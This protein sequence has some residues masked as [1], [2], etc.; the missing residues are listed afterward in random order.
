M[1]RIL[2][3]KTIN[4]LG[5]VLLCSLLPA[6]YL[7]GMGQDAKAADM[8][9]YEPIG[10]QRPIPI[11]ILWLTGITTI[12][13]GRT[14]L[15]RLNAGQHV[16][17]AREQAP[18]KRAVLLGAGPQAAHIIRG[19]SEDPQLRYDIIGI[20]DDR[21]E[22]H[23]TYVQNVRIIGP[24]NTLSR[25]L[26]EQAVDEVIVAVQDTCVEEI[27][28][29]VIECRRQKLPVKVAPRLSEI[30]G[31][32]TAFRLLDFSVEDFL[33]RRSQ[34]DAD[35]THTSRS[36]AGKRV[37]VTGAG[38]SIGSEICRQIASYGPECLVLLGHGENSVFYIRNELL[39]DFP[40]MADRVHW[41]I[42]SVADEHRLEQVF[43]RFRPNL[44]FHTAAHKH[45][46]V[47]EANLHEALQNNVLGTSYVAEACGRYGVE[48]MVLISTD[49]AAD[50]ISVMGATKLLA[51]EVVRVSAAA[52]TDT[53]YTTVRFGNVLG[54]RG[55]VVPIFREQIRRGG[56]V[57]ITHPDM[58]RYFMT[59]PEAVHLVLQAGALGQSGKLYLL[60][61]GM[62]VRILDLA[63]DMI[64]L[65]GYEPYTDIPIQFS[66]VRPGEKIHERLISGDCRMESSRWPGISVVHRPRNFAPGEIPEMLKILRH[67][68]RHGTEEELRLLLEETVPGYTRMGAP[69]AVASNRVASNQ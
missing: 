13:L 7:L 61:M 18:R 67:L 20:L 48:R 3:V 51:E 34:F 55:S 46:P 17:I 4:I 52:W 53:T 15:R 40:H 16:I 44:V 10:N 30:L 38:G 22:T 49:K 9:L 31:G 23:G 56:P 24:I 25:L 57:T 45:V 19:V 14:M 12:G 50:P 41:I 59:I 11:I 37:L 2:T 47:M 43:E 54:S 36:L 69:V 1:R 8:S 62:P 42:A 58:T 60:D 27:R 33:L 35:L 64:R 5:V 32:Q 65:C 26:A 68:T 39:M 66:G 6:M 29:Y 63:L 28:E 21:R